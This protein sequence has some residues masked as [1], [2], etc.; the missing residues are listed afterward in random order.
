MCCIQYTVS[1]KTLSQDI[2]ACIRERK[3]SF[4]KSV[5]KDSPWNGTY[6]GTR[7]CIRRCRLRNFLI[8]CWLF[9]PTTP[10]MGAPK[11]FSGRISWILLD[12]NMYSIQEKLH[13]HTYATDKNELQ[14]HC[15]TICVPKF[16]FCVLSPD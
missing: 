8:V 5:T 1:M 16:V 13:C 4:V 2:W 14:V 10:P 3:I 7:E 12:V 9:A 11:K 15:G 6:K